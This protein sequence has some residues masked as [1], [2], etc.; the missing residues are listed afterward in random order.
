MAVCIPGLM[1]CMS[2]WRYAYWLSIIH[3]GF[4][5]CADSGKIFYDMHPLMLQKQ[6]LFLQKK[7]D[8][9]FFMNNADPFLSKSPLKK[10]D[11]I[12]MYIWLQTCIVYA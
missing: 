8:P 3:A 5:V 6:K 1:V 2:G 12:G 7:R 10:S 4:S 9:R 11:M